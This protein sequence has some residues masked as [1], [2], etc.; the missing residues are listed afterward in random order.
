M[1]WPTRRR[2]GAAERRR[3]RGRPRCGERERPAPRRPRRAEELWFRP[4]TARSV[5]PASSSEPARPASRSIPSSG[6]GPAAAAGPAGRR[7]SSPTAAIRAAGTRSRPATLELKVPA[8]RFDELTDGLEPLGRLEFVN[9]SA[10]D[11]GEEFVDLAAGRQ[12]A[13]AGGAAD[14]AAARP[15]PASCRTC[16]RSSAS[17]RGCGRRS[18][19]S[20]GGCAI[21]RASA[22]AQPLSVS[23]HEPLP[24]V[25]TQR[26]G[27]QHRRGVPCG[28]AQL[29]GGARGVRSRR[30]GTW[31]R[32]SC[33]AG[34]WSSFGRSG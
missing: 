6:H 26:R 17:S 27:S 20:R 10:E 28:L 12:W 16:S 5:R 22:A 14:R 29:H 2:R 31:C 33:S 11:V 34:A 9:V 3:D 8:A 30:W 1:Q 25:A 21:S 7:L 24:I 4:T 18:S 32:S 13:P 15:G 19:E 23:L